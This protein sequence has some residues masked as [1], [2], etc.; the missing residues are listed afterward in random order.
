MKLKQTIL[1]VAISTGLTG[2]LFPTV[3]NANTD[4][5]QFGKRGIYFNNK[6][7]SSP[8]G[9]VANGTTYM[10]IWYVM[11]ALNQIGVRSTWDG[12]TWNLILPAGFHAAKN[13]IY[14]NQG[15]QEIAL[16]GTPIIHIN[17]IVYKD[18]SSSAP[19]MYMP[20]WDVQQVLR[21]L[22]FQ[23]SW[24]GMDWR[25]TQTTYT[26]FDSN[27]KK[28]G[29][30]ADRSDAESFLSSYPGGLVKNST[31]ITMYT[32]LDLLYAD[33]SSG[34]TQLGS[35]ATLTGA[36]QALSSVPLGT[37]Q[38]ISN[39]KV[40][41][42][43]P[44]YIAYDHSGKQ[45]GIF[46]TEAAAQASLS[47]LPGGTVKDASGRIVF[48]QPDLMYLD[49]SFS[50]SSLGSFNTLSDAENALSTSPL[51]VVKQQPGGSVIYTEPGYVAYTYAGEVLG[52]FSNLNAA[53]QAVANSP[54]GVVKDQHG[55]VA[56]LQPGY[57][58]FSSSWNVMGQYATL[59]QAITAVQNDPGATI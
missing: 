43:E 42:I 26:A 34:G 17:G 10:P 59:S 28:L 2:V 49:Y 38:Q 12:S 16:G 57:V 31:G 46:S 51:G 24:N 36:K 37:V 25:I 8:F 48:T 6:P 22:G 33:Y 52:V 15:A 45:L 13:K 56:Y 19:T 32:K 50:G 21:W 20:I 30:F 18:P 55:N 35:Y 3:S 9:F 1:V 41:Y 23:Y 14:L 54:V 4:I 47:K 29:V 7:V 39:G 40:V 5:S 11:S 27:G 44:G 53:Q 58:A